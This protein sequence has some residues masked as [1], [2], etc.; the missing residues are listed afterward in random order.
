MY[1]PCIV[2]S[3]TVLPCTV[4]SFSSSSLSCVCVM[5]DSSERRVLLT[6]STHSGER[7]PWSLVLGWPLSFSFRA[8]TQPHFIHHIRFLSFRRLLCVPALLGWLDHPNFRSTPDFGR[9]LFFL[10]PSHA[11]LWKFPGYNWWRH[12]YVRAFMKYSDMVAWTY[13]RGECASLLRA[14]LRP[15]PRVLPGRWCAVC[16]DVPAVQTSTPRNPV[17]GAAGHNRRGSSR[18]G[19]P[20][21]HKA[22]TVAGSTCIFV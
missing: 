10:L 17:N 4:S 3:C 6:C 1:R 13:D 7:P 8:L 12:G 11:T 5:E 15:A 2:L 22:G 9:V 20:Q 19:F 16:T 14:S 18:G 21:G